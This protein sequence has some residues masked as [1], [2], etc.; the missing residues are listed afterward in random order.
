MK[1][2]LQYRTGPKQTDIDYGFLEATDENSAKV[3]FSKN[4]L[5]GYCNY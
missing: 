5:F 4:K 3:W 1:Y 2:Y